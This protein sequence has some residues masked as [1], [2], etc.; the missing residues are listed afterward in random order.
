MS[1]RTSFYLCVRLPDKVRS[2]AKDT[3]CEARM[4]QVLSFNWVSL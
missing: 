3:N 1:E 2:I 4:Q